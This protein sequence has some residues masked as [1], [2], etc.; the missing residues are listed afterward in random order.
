MKIWPY[1]RNAAS[2][3]SIRGCNQHFAV[4]FGDRKVRIVSWDGKSKYAFIVWTLFKVEQGSNF[5]GNIWHVAKA[6]PMGRFYG[7]TMPFNT[8]LCTNSSE[9][10]GSHRKCL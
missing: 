6:D 8:K 1:T 5:S 7:E 2:I 3:I 10:I 9:L 4:G